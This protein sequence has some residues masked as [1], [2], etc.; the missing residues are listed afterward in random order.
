MMESK[1]NPQDISS[2]ILCLGCV[3]LGRLLRYKSK[4]LENQMT[5]SLKTKNS[6]VIESERGVTQEFVTL[7]HILES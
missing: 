1:G 2:Q 6:A 3:N 5:Q 4:E 7:Q